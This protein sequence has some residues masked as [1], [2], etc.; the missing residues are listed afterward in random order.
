MLNRRLCIYRFRV[1]FF[2]A[3]KPRETLSGT[4]HVIMIGGSDEM[5]IKFWSKERL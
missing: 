5:H 3:V 1:L 2:R 4:P